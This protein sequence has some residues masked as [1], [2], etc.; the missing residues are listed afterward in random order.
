MI[1]CDTNILIN[2]FNGRLDT[3]AEL[4]KIGIDNILIPSMTVMELYRGMSNKKEL[5][6]MKKKLRV[7][8]VLHINEA[9]SLKSVQLIEAYKLSHGLSIPDATSYGSCPSIRTLYLQP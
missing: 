1:L 4:D 5:A 6:D 3:I 2:A 8:D 7:Y 9:T